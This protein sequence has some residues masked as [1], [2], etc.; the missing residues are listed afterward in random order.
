MRSGGNRKR[1]QEGKVG[2]VRQYRENPLELGKKKV[3]RPERPPFKD[4]E[5][6]DAL[7]HITH[8]QAA[9]RGAKRYPENRLACWYH[10]MLTPRRSTFC[11][12]DCADVKK[13]WAESGQINI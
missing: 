7:A 12:P 3:S 13:M 2:S 1:G 8:Y 11:T 4:R 9:L 6:N 5:C 10:Q